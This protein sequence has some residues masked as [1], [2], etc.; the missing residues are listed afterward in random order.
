MSFGVLEGALDI[1]ARRRRHTAVSQ[2]PSVDLDRR[3]VQRVSC[4]GL[5][6]RSEPLDDWR[7]PLHGDFR[8]VCSHEDLSSPCCSVGV[9]DSFSLSPITTMKSDQRRA[10]FPCTYS[11]AR[12]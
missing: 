4:A 9:A 10:D 7:S 3:S 2:S 6:A 1:Y 5:A 8:H 12:G 11:A